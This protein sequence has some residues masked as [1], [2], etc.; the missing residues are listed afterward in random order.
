[1]ITGQGGMMQAWVDLQ[2]LIQLL[3]TFHG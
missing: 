1:M 2:E 3:K